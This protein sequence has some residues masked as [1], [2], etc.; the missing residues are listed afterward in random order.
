MDN[1]TTTP[2]G[3]ADQAEVLAEGIISYSTPSHGGI[4]LSA[5]RQREIEPVRAKNWLGSLEWWE[6][7]CDWSVPYFFFRADIGARARNPEEHARAVNAA[8][9]F[10]RRYQLADVANRLLSSPAALA[11]IP[12]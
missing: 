6:D 7:D 10:I 5:A 2:W 4:W 9:D 3:Q 12:A 1:R 8:Q 11:G